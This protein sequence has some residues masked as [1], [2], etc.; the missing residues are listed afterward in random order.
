MQAALRIASGDVRRIISGASR[1]QNPRFSHRTG[2]SI[3][4]A[5]V[6]KDSINRP[7]NTIH[8]S[9]SLKQYVRG[10]CGSFPI[11]APLDKPAFTQLESWDRKKY[12]APYDLYKGAVFGEEKP[13]GIFLHHAVGIAVVVLNTESKQMF[14]TLIEKQKHLDKLG[15]DLETLANA[16]NRSLSSL[17]VGYAPKDMTDE[18]LAKLEKSG[19]GEPEVNLVREYQP[20][21]VLKS[22]LF[23]ITAN[24]DWTTRISAAEF[25]YAPQDTT[26]VDRHGNP[27]IST[28]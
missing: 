2:S 14:A 3:P 25:A 17:L 7:E 20:N 12:G 22:T 26:G 23:A 10:L 13:L 18:V 6:N 21:K 16:G 9:H 4:A 24:G 11:V 19:L 5:L 15:P 1:F 27:F 8:S 28:S